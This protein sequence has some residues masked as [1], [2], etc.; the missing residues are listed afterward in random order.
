MP[1]DS[2]ITGRSAQ[3]RDLESDVA[4]ARHL[5][6]RARV[7][8]FAPLAPSSVPCGITTAIRNLVRSSISQ[9]H[10]LVVISTYRGTDAKHHIMSR[11]LYGAYLFVKSIIYIITRHASL[12]EIHT[13]SGRDFFK[14]GS[15][16]LAAKITGRPVILRIHGGG[17]SRLY[18]EYGPVCRWLTRFLLRMADKVVVLS[19]TSE[20]TI[21]KIETRVDTCII[22]NCLCFEDLPERIDADMTSNRHVLL[23]ANIDSNKGHFDV[24][25]AMPRVLEVVPDC[26]FVFAGAEREKGSLARMKEMIRQMDLGQHIRFL[27]PVSG[28]RK[29]DV[30]ADACVLILPSYVENMPLSIMEGMASGLPVIASSVGAIPE[31]VDE[32]VSGFLINPGDFASLAD[33]ICRLLRDTEFRRKMGM[34]GRE[35]AEELWH[36]KS[37]VQR[38]S[39]LYGQM[40]P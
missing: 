13:A 9:P 22:P 3:R 23:L 24:L 20:N 10:E 5:D 14:H 2:T 30:L 26:Q 31:M 29:R 11:L 34:K 1:R 8:V 32:G 18:A 39:A 15:I 33:K 21:I 12:V 40:L 37:V 28:Q 6:T 35:R 16:L 36:S 4:T 19:E 7:L 25:K 27:G 38:N 17:F